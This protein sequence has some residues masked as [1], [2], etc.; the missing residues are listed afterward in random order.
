MM[1]NMEAKMPFVRTKDG[2]VA[3]ALAYGNATSNVRAVVYLPSPLEE[4]EETQTL[5]G[6]SGASGA[7]AA[8]GAAGATGAG[9]ASAAART[10]T[11]AAWAELSENLSNGR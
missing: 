6:E 1:M 7:A 8:A 5:S 9:A 11:P 4:G 2:A 3:V 10:M